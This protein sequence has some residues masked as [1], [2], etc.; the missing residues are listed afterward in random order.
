VATAQAHPGPAG[1]ALLSVSR[2]AFTASMQ[3]TSVLAMVIVVAASL[4]AAKIL[5][6]GAGAAAP[7]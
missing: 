1:D 4:V 5:R 7:R 2:A 6:N 3:V